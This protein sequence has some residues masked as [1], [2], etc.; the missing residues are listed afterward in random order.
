MVLVMS[1]IGSVAAL[2]LAAA[3]PAARCAGEVSGRGGSSV[4]ATRGPPE[5]RGRG[6][7]SFDTPEAPAPAPAPAPVAG[8]FDPNGDGSGS[9]PDADRNE[10]VK[11]EPVEVLSSEADEVEAWRPRAGDGV[12]AEA[13]A[14]RKDGVDADDASVPPIC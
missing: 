9:G 12:M 6:T 3:A 14:G 2:A 11:N 5:V 4:G 8:K 10:D 1:G 7:N 13:V